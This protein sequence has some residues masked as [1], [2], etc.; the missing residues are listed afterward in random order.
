MENKKITSWADLQKEV[1]KIAGALGKDSDLLLA[2][3]SN[4]FYALEDLGYE[5]DPSLKP[6][7]EDKIRFSENVASKLS[8][9]REQIFK[10]T[11]RSFDVR[12]RHE[13]NTVLFDEM[14]LEA[15]DERG[16]PLK[17]DVGPRDRFDLIKNYEELHPIVPL[18]LEFRTIDN[19]TPPLSDK[20]TYS[21]V[22]N[23]ATDLKERIS[24]TIHFKNKK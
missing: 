5:I 21:Q 11:G 23:G 24:L 12:D 19:T 13:L 18:L 10:H 17:K 6:T 4:P 20:S 8:M 14:G 7:F 3:A 22:R 16:C 9:L 15:F 2:A 1:K